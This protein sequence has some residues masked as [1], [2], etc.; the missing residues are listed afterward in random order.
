MA[1]LWPTLTS[2]DEDFLK[3]VWV[4]SC[5]VPCEKV[6]SYQHH[7]NLSIHQFF[8]EHCH[9]HPYHWKTTQALQADIST[10]IALITFRSILF[11]EHCFVF[12]YYRSYPAVLPTVNNVKDVSGPVVSKDPFVEFVFFFQLIFT[13]VRPSFGVEGCV[14]PHPTHCMHWWTI[15]A[16]LGH[17]K[18]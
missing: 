5:F 17:K 4:L 1:L 18:S 14:R 9:P 3:G 7:C 2:F 6:C 8:C 13:G 11:L 16:I 15:W 12:V 10:P